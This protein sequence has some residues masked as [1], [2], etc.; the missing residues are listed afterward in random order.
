MYV[1][2][3]RD[4]IWMFNQQAA[5]RVPTG[6]GGVAVNGTAAYRYCLVACIELPV[7]TCLFLNTQQHSFTT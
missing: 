3:E 4:R 5:A 6:S 7:L 2:L 1:I